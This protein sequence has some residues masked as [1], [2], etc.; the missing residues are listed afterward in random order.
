MTLRCNQSDFELFMSLWCAHFVEILMINIGQ[1]LASWSADQSSD[2][3]FYMI[4]TVWNSLDVHLNDGL[5]ITIDIY[6]SGIFI[7]LLCHEIPIVIHCCIRSSPSSH[8]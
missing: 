8:Y 7:V 5:S 6:G 1:C 4:L 2:A 3:Y